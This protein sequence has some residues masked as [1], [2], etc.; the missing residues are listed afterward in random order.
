[1]QIV[2]FRTAFGQ[3]WE[4]CTTSSCLI[5]QVL[6]TF[7]FG[8]LAGKVEALLGLAQAKLEFIIV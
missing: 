4:I 8:G 5:N 7:K 3:P 2:Q 6:G 1:M